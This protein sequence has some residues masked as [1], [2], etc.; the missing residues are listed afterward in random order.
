MT[1]IE[2]NQ[3]QDLRGARPFVFALVP[4]PH[5]RTHERHVTRFLSAKLVQDRVTLC[6]L[7]GDD[8]FLNASN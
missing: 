6:T 8:C 5:V 7:N 4:F 1:S 2:E 3:S